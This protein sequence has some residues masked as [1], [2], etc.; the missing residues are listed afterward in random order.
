MKQGKFYALRVLCLILILSMLIYGCTPPP[1][2]PVQQEPSGPPMEEPKT[3][4]PAAP[5]TAWIGQICPE[6]GPLPDEDLTYK[7]E[8]GEVIKDGDYFIRTGLY[9]NKE[10]QTF[11][12][13][14]KGMDERAVFEY[15]DNLKVC[16]ELLE[17]EE[18]AFET[19][20]TDEVT[21][22]DLSEDEVLR[23]NPENLLIVSNPSEANKEF[24]AEGYIWVYLIDPGIGNGATHDYRK[25]CRN[26]ADTTVSVSSAG[27]SVRATHYRRPPGGLNFASTRNVGTGGSTRWPYNTR[28]TYD[29]RVIGTSAGTTRYSVSGTIWNYGY[30]SPAP[31]GGGSNCQ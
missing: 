25:Y 30:Y 19:D 26:S 14:V 29:L 1:S 6:T 20:V 2:E 15:T 8:F 3:E 12:I 31:S 7:P 23:E 16:M 27:G 18:S 11:D 24:F 21:G 9:T 5:V 28:A 17:I 10:G 4:E 13:T 22:D